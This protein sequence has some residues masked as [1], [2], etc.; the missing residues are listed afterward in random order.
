M[1]QLAQRFNAQQVR[2][3]DPDGG[4]GLP[5]GN[6]PVYISKTEVVANKDAST[7]HQLVLTLNCYDGPAKGSIALWRLSC[8]HTVSQDAVRIAYEQLSAVC[9]VVGKFDI[10][11]T[12]ELVNLP[13][14]AVVESQNDPQ[15]PNRTQIKGVLDKNGDKP[16]QPGVKGKVQTVTAAPAP[17][18]AA[19]APAPWTPGGAAAPAAPA[20]AAWGP[21]SAAP[22]PA[23]PAAAP[24]AP[25]AGFAP[26]G[27][28]P[29]APANVWTPG[30]PPPGAPGAGAAPGAP[31]WAGVPR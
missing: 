30:T 8:Y 15:Y 6:H 13:F 7:G 29:S 19:P 2:P 17:S 11:D 22:A 14:I 1:V 28:P 18:A 20:T 12:D 31:A 3:A 16:G 21:S 25:A 27:T 24:V 26:P 5:V 4:A 10:G 23:A 9:H